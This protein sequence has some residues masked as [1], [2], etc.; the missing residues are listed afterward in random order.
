MGNQK[1]FDRF[2]IAQFLKIQKIIFIATKNWNV[3]YKKIHSM[4][5]YVF[6]YSLSLKSFPII[7]KI[8]RSLVL[9]VT[10]FFKK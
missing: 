10:R 7:G 3:R 8:N 1:Q 5:I 9:I 2:F 4:D 6:E